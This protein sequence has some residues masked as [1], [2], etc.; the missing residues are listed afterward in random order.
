MAH[1]EYYKRRCG[2]TTRQVDEWIQQLFNGEE[3]VIQDHAYIDG[4]MAN[5]H[6]KRVLLGRLYG[7]HGLSVGKESPLKVDGFKINILPF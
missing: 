5:E 4:N 7:E 6:A 1:I 2:N 3:V